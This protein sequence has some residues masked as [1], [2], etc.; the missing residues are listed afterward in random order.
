MLERKYMEVMEV[1]TF[2]T[3]AACAVAILHYCGPESHRACKC[4]RIWMDH[5]LL[6]SVE[7]WILSRAG[8]CWGPLQ[9]EV[10]PL[11]PISVHHHHIRCKL[12]ATHHRATQIHSQSIP[13]P[14]IPFLH[15]HSISDT[16]EC[17]KTNNVEPGL[18]NLG[19]L[20]GGVSCLLA[21]YQWFPPCGGEPHYVTV[22]YQPR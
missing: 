14:M 13:T 16:S 10:L 20:I 17:L 15:I 21:D 1:H 18:I 19:C 11:S 7:W 2:R 8:L 9:F 4:L 22:I 3:A 6:S 12:Q 5:V